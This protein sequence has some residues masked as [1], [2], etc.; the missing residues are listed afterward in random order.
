MAATAG[1]SK[2]FVSVIVPCR[3]EAAFLGPCLDSILRGDY[4]PN[5]MEVLVADGMS[6]DGSTKLIEDY[7]SRDARVRLVR[8]PGR[9]TPAAL[10][11]AIEAARG[12]VIVRVDAHSELA[13]DYIALSVDYLERCGADNVGGVM[14]TVP[15]GTGPFAEPIRIVLTHRF[16]VGDSHF[17]TGIYAPRWVDT[18]FGGCWRRETFAR[19]GKFNERLAR[20]QDMEFNLR[21]RRAGGKILLAPDIESTYFARTGLG[22]FV[23]HNWTN[24]VWAVLP[25]AYSS[26][27]PVRWRHLMPLVF[28]A[29]L[30]G[31]GAAAVLQASLRWLPALVAAPYLALS[32]AASVRA[33]MRERNA[34][35]AALLPMA[36]AALH[37]AYGFGSAWGAIRLAGI[38]LRRA[39]RKDRV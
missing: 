9:I 16:G 32:M 20:G 36:F 6:E 35:L 7:T 15:R 38:W 4:P 28:V 8:N 12:D 26:V 2:P 31:C 37:L 39:V 18:V 21:L 13:P 25:F 10:N 29:G 14:R 22:A 1:I 24:G 3:N 19:V 23:R 33:A 27:A 11:R 34:K 17:R 30:A 5:R